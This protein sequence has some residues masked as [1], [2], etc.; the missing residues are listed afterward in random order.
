[1]TG[2]AETPRARGPLRSPTFWLH[3]AALVVRQRVEARLQPL[4][5]TYTQFTL[6]GSL[7]W[8]TRDDHVP[9]QQEVA[10]HAGADR[11]MTSRVLRALE[12]RGLLARDADQDDRR[13]VR[14]RLTP[15]GR[16]VLQR[17]VQVVAEVDAELF[18][19]DDGRERLLGD[20]QALAGRRFVVGAVGP[21]S[22]SGAS[23]PG[24]PRRPATDP[25]PA[26]EDPSAGCGDVVD[27]PR[28]GVVS[29]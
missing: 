16:D 5:V 8:L 3:H 19:A 25:R 12:E 15:E 14:L 6:L 18:G 28:P 9:T 4:G 22:V 11:M 21:R 23:G 20:L 2:P 24:R 1:M 17:A 29:G 13:A 26:H 7:S 10:R 27:P